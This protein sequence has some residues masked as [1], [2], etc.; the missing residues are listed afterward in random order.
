MSESSRLANQMHVMTRYVASIGVSACLTAFSFTPTIADE[1]LR[2]TEPPPSVA[3][4][5]FIRN[6][7]FIPEPLLK[8]KK[9]GKYVTG[10][11]AVGWDAEEGFNMGGFGEWYDN[12]SRTDPFFRTAPYRTKTFLGGTVSTEDTVKLFARLDWLY[13][14]DTPFRF[15]IDG[16]YEKNPIKNY[17]GQGDDGIP[18]IS[19]RTGKHFDSFDIYQNH[20]NV[21]FNRPVGACSPGQECTFSRF[22]KYDSTDLIFNSTLEYDLMGGLLRPLVGIQIRHVK[23]RDYT[24]KRVDIIGQNGRATQASTRLKLDCERGITE[25][26][27]GGWDNQIRIGLT[28]DSRNFEPNPTS[29]V[30]A[31]ANFA[32]S[33]KF[34]GSKF[35]YQRLTLSGAFYH[36]FFQGLVDDQQ[37]ILA[38]RAAYN[39]NFG[40]APFYALSRMG[41]NDFDRF[42][43]GGF[44]TLR[45]YKTQR[46]IGDSSLLMNGE[47]RWFFSEWMLWGQHL[48]PGISV[49]G[50]IGRSYED[51][52]LK[53]DDIQGAGGVG[54]R[55]AWNLAT[56]ISFDLGVSKEDKIF[57]MELGTMF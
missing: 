53:L 22:N 50:D 2:E 5:Y 55:L 26:C 3:R 6:K 15:R 17:F 10:I 23:I 18:L 11:P 47:L 42:G 27:H 45:G 37:L 29:G 16:F 14:H 36:D 25:G 57:Y 24:G 54:F 46:F 20:L 1:G 38:T 13:V 43:L 49:F 34:M 30:L 31:Q 4:P 12:G 33:F 48:K 56:M 40:N 28:Y 21:T 35:A 52:Q 8:D 7:P 9:E 41:F 19:P 39:M 32:T 51:I 44:W